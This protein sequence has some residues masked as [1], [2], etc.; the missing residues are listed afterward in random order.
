MQE[1]ERLECLWG[2]VLAI[3]HHP[4][5]PYRL[6]IVPKVSLRGRSAGKPIALKLG[7]AASQ[8]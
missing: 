8:F 3:L 7:L 2:L 6:L 4:R 5:N 1:K